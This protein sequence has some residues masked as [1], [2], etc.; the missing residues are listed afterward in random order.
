M[1]RLRTATISAFAI[2]ST[3]LL[4]LPASAAAVFGADATAKLMVDGEVPEGLSIA[5]DTFVFD[6][7]SFEF[8]NASATTSGFSDAPGT[9]LLDQAAGIE[10]RASRTAIGSVA[11]ALFLTDGFVSF[12]NTTADPLE[13]ALSLV[14]SVSASASTMNPLEEAL[15]AA[16][17][18]LF[19]DASFFRI[20]D[21]DAFLGDLGESLEGVFDFS[22]TI[23]PEETAELSLFVDVDGFAASVPVPASLPLFGT[24]LLG[25]G[26][27]R[28]RRR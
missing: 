22:L 24:A 11:E 6:D 28:I 7:F 17:V 16:S 27:V 14:W 9:P 26:L 4:S 3:A 8:G 13:I 18:D 2:L 15:S 19:G 21:A 12:E 1:S 20:A 25:L 23:A 5:S 10:G